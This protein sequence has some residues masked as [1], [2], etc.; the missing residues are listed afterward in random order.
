MGLVTVRV[1]PR[2]AQTSVELDERGIIV[3]VPAAPEAGRATDAAR[4]AL[5]DALGVPANRIRLRRGTRSRTKV[6]EIAGV[7]QL[8][9]EVRLRAT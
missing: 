5:A 4:R 7:G 6:F 8:D 3:R 1:M 2:S 9:A